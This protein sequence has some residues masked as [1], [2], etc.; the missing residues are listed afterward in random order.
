MVSQCLGR[1]ATGEPCSA[2]PVRP[3]GYCY[4]HSPATAQEREAARRRGGQNRSNRARAAKQ[5]PAG[6]MTPDEVLACLGNSIKGVLAGEI[7][8]GVAN[9]VA[10]LSRAFVAVREASALERI[11]ERLADLERTASRGR[12]A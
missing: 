11:E 9:S 2:Q 8:P 6:S 10:N 5:L 12:S 3:D 4:W 7:E 1:T